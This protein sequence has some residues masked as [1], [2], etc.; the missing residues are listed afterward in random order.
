MKNIVGLLIFISISEFC[1]STGQVPDYL[2]INNDTIAIFSNPLEQY[3]D[4]V[5][6][7][8][9]IG[10]K[11]CGSTACWR[12]Y[13]AIWRLKGDSLFLTAITSCHSDDWCPAIKDADLGL[14]FGEYFKNNSVF[15]YWFTGDIM[16]PQ[17]EL[18][19]YIHMG[20]A[21]IYAKE[22]Y[23]TFKNGKNTKVRMKSNANL[24]NKIRF[25]NKEKEI[26]KQVQDTLFYYVKKYVSWDTVITPYYL[27]CDEKYILT[28]NR[29]GKIKKAWVDWEGETFREKIDDWW[30][31]NTDDRKC[32]MTIKKA[33]KPLRLLYLDLPKKRFKITFE[34]FY[35]RKTGTLEL[36]KESWMEDE[37]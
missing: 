32:R 3:F 31:N 33:I 10:L 18:V 1:F 34:V 9:I 2:V 25:H 37:Q 20:Y 26:S 17:G 35:D 12:G 16:A 13:K 27:L 36:L 23:F 4:K 15:A 11:G 24:A 8:E 14:M 19:Q 6:N 7:R 29:A 21:S 22:K 5:G 30:W 28:Y